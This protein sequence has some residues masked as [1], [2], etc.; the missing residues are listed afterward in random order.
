MEN[1]GIL[2]TYR[3]LGALIVNALKKEKIRE[4]LER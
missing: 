1:F 3:G 2:Q 4:D